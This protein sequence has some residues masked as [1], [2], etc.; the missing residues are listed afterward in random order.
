MGIL[1]N[2]EEILGTLEASKYLKISKQHLITVVKKQKLPHI[3]LGRYYK[4]TKSSL[5]SWINQN[6]CCGSMKEADR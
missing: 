2:Q 3:R 1:M 5:D 4:F 6:L